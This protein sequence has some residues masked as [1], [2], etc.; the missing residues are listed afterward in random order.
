M[1]KMI[2]F[3]IEYRNILMYI[4][5]QRQVFKCQMI[6]IICFVFILRMPVF[7][8]FNLFCRTPELN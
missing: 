5:V 6:V 8:C 7:C 1:M 3:I 2:L 4:A